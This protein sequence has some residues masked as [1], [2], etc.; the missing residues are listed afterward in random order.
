MHLALDSVAVAQLIE[1]EGW[2]HSI[3]LVVF[4]VDSVEFAVAALDCP[5]RI[6]AAV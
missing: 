3:A 2:P 5:E 4:E 6:A 1:I